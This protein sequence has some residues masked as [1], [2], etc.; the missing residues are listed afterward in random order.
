MKILFLTCIVPVGGT[1]SF[2]RSFS[3]VCLEQKDSLFLLAF[4][5]GSKE[6]N[7]LAFSSKQI[8]YVKKPGSFHLFHILSRTVKLY[9]PLARVLQKEDIE[10][11]V[12]DLIF[13]A[14][15]LLLLRPFFQKRLKKVK[16]L[17]QF[18]GLDSLESRFTEN[19]QNTLLGQLRFFYKLAIESIALKYLPEK[20]IVFSQYAKK[21]L[22]RYFDSKKIVQIAPGVDQELSYAAKSLSKKEAKDF[23]G[24]THEKKIVLI[25]SRLEKRKGVLHFLSK[26]LPDKPKKDFLLYVVSDFGTDG[27]VVGYFQLLSK[28]LFSTGVVS[29]S[30]LGRK[31]LAL[32]YKAADLVVVPSLDLETFG[33]TSLEAMSIGTPVVAYSIG[34]NSELLPK[35]LL[36]EPYQTAKMYK[37][38]KD[39]LSMKE[40]SRIDLQNQMK[41]SAKKYSWNR[42]LQ[43]VKT[44]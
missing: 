13:P 31:D 43:S 3:R 6:Q 23:L 5:N 21:L 20:I 22:G 28:M 27:N 1:T 18:H 29:V 33:L 30:N 24:I 40:S 2:L 36:V 35:N 34:A 15:S 9:N 10:L 16:I 12:V 41:R 44:L 38:I 7:D 32:I 37:K 39:V 42:Y 4:S 8:I 14:I 19:G 26:V 25:V 11:I 17:Y